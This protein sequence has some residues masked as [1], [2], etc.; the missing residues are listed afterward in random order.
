VWRMSWNLIAGSPALVSA[1]WN[2]RDTRPASSGVPMLVVN[3]W[4]ESVHLDPATSR[5]I[6]CRVRCPRSAVIAMEGSGTLRCSAR[7]S[8]PPEP[9]ARRSSPGCGAPSPNRPRGPPPPN[10]TPAARP[11]ASLWRARSP[12]GRGTD[13]RPRTRSTPSPRQDRAARSR[14]L[15]RG[16]S[17]SLAT[18]RVTI[19]Q[20]SAVRRAIDSTVRIISTRRADSPDA[21][22]G[23]GLAD[24]TRPAGAVP[25]LVHLR[26]RTAARAGTWIAWTTWTTWTSDRRRCL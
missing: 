6:R 12:T 22:R 5:S 17:T 11:G 7:S 9:I 16:P 1:R 23:R 18:L 13:H 24:W 2:A 26:D 21:D 8:A 10:G 19:P 25:R 3:T 14:A 4:P 20:R 15:L